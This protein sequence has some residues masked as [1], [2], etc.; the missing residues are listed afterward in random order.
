MMWTPEN[1]HF[2]LGPF[3]RATFSQIFFFFFSKKNRKSRKNR[4]ISKVWNLTEGKIFG[5]LRIQYF[6]KKKWKYGNTKNCAN[7]HPGN[8]NKKS[9]GKKG[10]SC[11]TA[12]T[13]FCTYDTRCKYRNMSESRNKNIPYLLLRHV[14][15]PIRS[16]GAGGTCGG[17]VHTTPWATCSRSKGNR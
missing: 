2:Y 5:R 8:L 14:Y 1:Q 11:N 4:N 9:F 16:T 15:F 3:Y 13:W 12:L 17:L 7:P 10:P 6:G